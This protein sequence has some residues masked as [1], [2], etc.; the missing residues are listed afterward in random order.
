MKS[1]RSGNGNV[2]ARCT[3]VVGLHFVMRVCRYSLEHCG[4]VAAQADLPET[5]KIQTHS[6]SADSEAMYSRVAPPAA[7]PPCLDL[8]RMSIPGIG[9]E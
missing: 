3:P 4:L 6:V 1:R 7:A 2:G 8:N 5:I 9:A